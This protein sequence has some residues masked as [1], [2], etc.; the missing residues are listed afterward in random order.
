MT[1]LERN[2]GFRR[3]ALRVS[4]QQTITYAGQLAGLGRDS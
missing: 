2:A 4:P 1:P 3:V